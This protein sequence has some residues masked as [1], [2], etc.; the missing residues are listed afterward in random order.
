MYAHMY[1]CLSELV[2]CISA[3]ARALAHECACVCARAAGAAAQH[4][5]TPEGIHHVGMYMFECVHVHMDVRL[6]CMQVC[7]R[8]RTCV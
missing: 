6:D 3:C 5:R 8:V 4:E 1:V 2:E 7:V